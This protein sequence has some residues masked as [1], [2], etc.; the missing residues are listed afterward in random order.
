MTNRQHNSREGVI[1][2]RVERRGEITSLNMGRLTAKMQR[3]ASHRALNC[4]LPDKQW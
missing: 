1:D 3:E 4:L 2:V